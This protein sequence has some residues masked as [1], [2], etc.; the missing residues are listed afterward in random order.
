MTFPKSKFNHLYLYFTSIKHALSIYS[1]TD[2]FCKT[3][4]TNFIFTNSWLPY[5]LLGAYI[6][7]F[8]HFVF[9]VF[10]IKMGQSRPLFVYFRSFLI[11]IS[12]QFEKSIDGMLGIRTQ[13]HRMVGT[14]KTTEL[15][16]PPCILSFKFN[17]KMTRCRF[18]Y[19]F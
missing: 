5:L 18:V 17:F 9:S 19:L 7:W 11:T 8:T 10:F 16:R 4:C 3:S 15:W 12:I 2:D 14:D 13:G 6:N 1:I